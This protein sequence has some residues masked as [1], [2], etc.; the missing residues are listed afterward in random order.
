MHI[1]KLDAIESTN[2][3]LKEL[4]TNQVVEN[5]TV[6]SSECQSGG[7]GQMGAKWISEPGK[8]LLFSVFVKDVSLSLQDAVYLNYAVS[9]AIYNSFSAYKL[10]NLKIKWPNDILADNKKLSGILIENSISNQV[11]QNTVIGVGLNVNQIEFSKELNKATSL[12]NILEYDIDKSELLN[13]LL[14][15]LKTQIE[16]CTPV[17]FTVLKQEYLS[18]LYKMHTPSMFKNAAKGVFMGKIVGVNSKGDL[19][20]ELEDESV[21]NFGLK[22]V[23]FL[24]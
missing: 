6:V 7:R 1:I 18:K 21:E 8:N 11:I 10:P 15:S 23:E 20:I 16:R 9:I 3:F 19:Q 13:S 22:E 17:N 5:Y 24:R 14:L 12:K 2:T 4:V